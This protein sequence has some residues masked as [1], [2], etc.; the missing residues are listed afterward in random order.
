MLNY[1]SGGKLSFI[2]VKIS[3]HFRW[4]NIV[5]DILTHHFLQGILF[6]I[7]LWS[8]FIINYTFFHV[9]LLLLQNIVYALI[10]WLYSFSH[11]QS[12]FWIQSIFI[13]LRMRLNEYTLVLFKSCLNILGVPIFR[14]RWV[15]LRRI[16]VY[17]LVFDVFICTLASTLLKDFWHFILF[18]NISIFNIVIHFV[19]IL[20]NLLIPSIWTRTS[21][22]I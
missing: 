8:C 3:I 12:P 18:N 19:Q 14:N 11:M 13:T 2:L 7:L 1:N 5:F 6:I 17:N 10:I 20:W 9:Q 22:I 4:N 21:T 15:Y 16:L